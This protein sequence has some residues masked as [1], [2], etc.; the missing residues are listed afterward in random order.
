MYGITQVIGYMGLMFP[1]DR[2]GSPG[3]SNPG[4][5]GGC[6]CYQYISGG[7]NM[8]VASNNL[9]RQG[10]DEYW[11][12]PLLRPLIAALAWA[13]GEGGHASGGNNTA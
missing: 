4:Y 2:P 8:A 3:G 10:P 12:D 13:N 6:Q 7:G 11:I 9:P 5:Q 1:V